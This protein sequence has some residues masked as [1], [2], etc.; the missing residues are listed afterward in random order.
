MY[1]MK[2]PLARL[3]A[4]NA[5]GAYLRDT[6]VNMIFYGNISLEKLHGH[7]CKIAKK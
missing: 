5:G 3:R 1:G 4:K 6:M 2:I 7:A